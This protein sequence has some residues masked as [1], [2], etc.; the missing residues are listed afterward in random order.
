MNK[1]ILCIFFALIN[2][3]LSLPC[4]AKNRELHIITVATKNT[5][6][7]QQLRDSC[8]ENG[9][10]LTVL[11][12][13]MVYPGNGLKLI[14]IDEFLKTVHKNDIVL[15]VDAYD[16]LILADEKTILKKFY[17]KNTPVIVSAE[18]FCYP[19]L[20]RDEEFPPSPTPFR[21]INTGS[22]MGY[23]RDLKQILRDMKPLIPNID[24]QGQV[25]EFFLKNKHRFFLDYHADLFLTLH[26]VSKDSLKVNKKARKVKCL[27]TGSTPLLV[28]GNG[29]GKDLY[30]ELYQVLFGTQDEL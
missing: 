9:L 8:D 5:Q 12:M 14:L 4:E 23:V 19:L 1:Y 22:I 21:F 13:G 28:H 10:D 18:T 29:N 16:V 11:G 24:D 26:N 15:F 30:N 3:S 27:L 6:G 2:L 25:A 7:L 17:A 20:L